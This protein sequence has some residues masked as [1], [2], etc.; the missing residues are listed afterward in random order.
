[1]YWPGRLHRRHAG[2][3]LWFDLTS[4]PKN[5]GVYFIIGNTKSKNNLK[6]K[7]GRTADQDVKFRRVHEADY[8]DDPLLG[9]YIM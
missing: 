5:F 1:M 2:Q 7:N 6:H 9:T 3:G 4:V 8:K